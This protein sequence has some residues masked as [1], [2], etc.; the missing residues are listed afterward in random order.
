MS[1]ADPKKIRRGIGHQKDSQAAK[2]SGTGGDNAMN[3]T[4]SFEETARSKA[5]EA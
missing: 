5:A 3:L 2:N 1:E 4:P